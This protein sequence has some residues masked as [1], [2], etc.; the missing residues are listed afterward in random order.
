MTVLDAR[1]TQRYDTAAN[2]SSNNPLL[3]AGEI[4]IESDTYKIKIGN[5]TSLWNSL[6]YLEGQIGSLASLTDVDTSAPALQNGSALVY[7]NGAWRPGPVIGFQDPS[8]DPNFSQVDLLMH[9]DDFNGSTSFLDDSLSN[10]TFI[11]VGTPIIS[12]AQYK[13][14]GSSLRLGYNG[15]NTFSN[16]I[17]TNSNPTAFLGTESFTFECWI[18]IDP[19]TTNT[20][21]HNEYIFYVANQAKVIDTVSNPYMYLTGNANRSTWNLGV[22]FS[23][24]TIYSF[25]I[26]AT[27]AVTIRQWTHV[28][29]VKQYNSTTRLYVNGQQVGSSSSGSTLP[30]SGTSGQFIIGQSSTTSTF[31]SSNF[32]GY[33]D[34]MRI[35]I[36]TPRY[37]TTTFTVPSAPFPSSLTT[38]PNII[39]SINNHSDVNLGSGA[40]EGQ[41]L[42]WNATSSFFEPTDIKARK[43]LG[44]TPP[45]LATDAG[46]PGEIRYD[47]N[48][49]YICTASNTWVRSSLSTW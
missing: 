43:I 24:S 47:S 28:A 10:R 6:T 3:L 49:V 9:Y 34:E 22:T 7:N 37:T 40:A 27:D 44:T 4:G 39:Y 41:T 11:R 17:Y 45:T 5:G 1:Q 38:T 21:N 31:S 42:A 20:T 18:Y 32:R 48:Y 25:S 8:T 19:D 30:S 46:V 26:S 15:Y 13:F 33:I 23:R 14:G 12:T 36:G 35:T 2:W 29:L 16:S